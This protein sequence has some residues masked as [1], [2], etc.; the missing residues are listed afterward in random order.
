MKTKEI[1]FTH[2]N[3][4]NNGHN[5]NFIREVALSYRYVHKTYHIK[6]SRCNIMQ[7][8]L[9][10]NSFQRYVELNDFTSIFLQKDATK[11]YKHDLHNVFGG[12][13]IIWI[14]KSQFAYKHKLPSCDECIIKGII[15]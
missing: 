1:I 14:E 4:S 5:F 12:K 8:I 15:E 10:P 13:D 6:C 3:N 2:F 7:V 9:Q 11:Y